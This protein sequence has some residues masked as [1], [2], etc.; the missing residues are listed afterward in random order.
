MSELKRFLIVTPAY[1]SGG[2][3]YEPPEV[4]ADVVE[5]EA[6]TARDAVAIGVKLMLAGNRKFYRYCRN[7]R[8][9]G[10]SPYAGVRAILQVEELTP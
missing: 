7:Q 5:V 4:G 3:Y 6:E 1:E 8:T 10:C 9:N 2:D